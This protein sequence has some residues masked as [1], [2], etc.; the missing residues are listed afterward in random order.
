[1]VDKPAY[2]S[3]ESVQ[4]LYCVPVLRN[5]CIIVPRILIVHFQSFNIYSYIKIE[6]QYNLN[7]SHT[8]S[9]FTVDDSNSFFSP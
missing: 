6:L 3:K 7:G 4:F 8:D 1:M 5:I 2:W 9:S